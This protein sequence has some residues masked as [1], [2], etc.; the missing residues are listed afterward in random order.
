MTQFERI[1][2]LLREHG[3]MTQRDIA[4]DLGVPLPNIYKA[5]NWLRITERVH[6]AGYRR[7]EDSGKLAPRA[8][9]ADGHGRMARGL[10]T[11]MD[12]FSISARMESG[13][14]R[15]AASSSW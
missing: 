2:A 11:V 4:A 5:V 1:L 15:S 14:M 8:L 7:D 3:P 6:I 10:R 9:W 12:F 13:T